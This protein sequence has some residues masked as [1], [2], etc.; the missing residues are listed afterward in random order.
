MKIRKARKGDL[1]D[2]AELFRI[3][4]AKKP[5]NQAWVEKTAIQK[6]KEL[7]NTQEIYVVIIKNDIV[8][9]ITILSKL[10]SRG[11]E[12]D[13]DELWL[14][15]NFHGRGIGTKLIEFVENKYK[16]NSISLSLISD[17]N[18]NAFEFYKKLKFKI[19]EDCVLMHK[20]LR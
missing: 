12:R 8:G 11:E 16:N 10:G 18:S 4:S 15:S 13:I 1:K 20:S 5:Y 9:F 6:I 2:I 3:E 17:P 7:F 19:V 14:N